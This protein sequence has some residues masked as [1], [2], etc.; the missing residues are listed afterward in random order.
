MCLADLC[1]RQKNGPDSIYLAHRDEKLAQE[2]LVME[3]VEG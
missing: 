1:A 2:A 3:V